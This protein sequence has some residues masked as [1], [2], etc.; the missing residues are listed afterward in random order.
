MLDAVAEIN[1]LRSHAFGDPEIETHIAQ[2]ELAHRMQSS[3][4]ELMD[5]S[6]EPEHV[7]ARYGPD[8]R[9]PGTYAAN[10]LL[11]RRLAERGVRVVQLFIVAGTSIWICR[12]TSGYRPATPTTPRLRWSKI[13]KSAAFWTTPWCS[14][15][16]SSDVPCIAKAS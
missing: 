10:C 3:V 6:G 12:A 2:Y 11:A 8:S 14:G 4:P 15:E 7:F 16:A 1:R 5:L 9:K 13:S